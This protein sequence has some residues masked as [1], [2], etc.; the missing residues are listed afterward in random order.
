MILGSELSVLKYD[1]LALGDFSVEFDFTVKAGKIVGDFSVQGGSTPAALLKFLEDGSIITYDGTVKLC[2]YDRRTIHFIINYEVAHHLFEIGVNGKLLVKKYSADQG[3]IK[4]IFDKC[5]TVTFELQPIGGDAEVTVENLKAYEKTGLGYDFARDILLSGK[6]YYPDDYFAKEILKE[7]VAWHKRSGILTVDGIKVIEPGGAEEYFVRNTRSMPLQIIYTDE[8]SNH[9]G[10]IIYGKTEKEAL[11][12]LTKEERQKLNDYCFYFRP[13]AEKILS[14]Y[15]TSECCQRHPRVLSS[16]GEFKQLRETIRTDQYKQEWFTNLIA[17]CDDVLP[18]QET[19]RYEL[20]DGV[21]LLY[22][23]SDFSQWM[24]CL[25]LAYQLTGKRK[26][27]KDAWRHIEAVSSFPDWNPVHHIDVGT[28]GMGFAVAYDWFYECMTPKQRG[29][30]ENAVSRNLFWIVNNAHE[31]KGTSYGNVLMEDNHNPFCNAGI[32]ACCMAFMDVFPEVTSNIASRTIRVL[33]CFLDKFVPD[34]A[35]FEGPDYATVAVGFTVRMFAVIKSCL[36][37]LYGLDKAEGFSL[38]ASYIDNMQSDVGAF[39]FADGDP[40]LVVIPGMLW[41]YDHYGIKGKK[42][43]LIKN[44]LKKETGENAAYCLLWYHPE[45][46]ECQEPPVLDVYYCGDD[47]ISMRN[48]F[49][50]GQVFAAIKA[51]KTE[52]VHSH[53]DPGSF[54]FDAGGKRWAFDLGKDDYNLEYK[55]G[56]YDIFRRRAEAHN[57]LLINPNDG[58]MGYVLGSRAD[59]VRYESDPRNVIV[60]I[61]TTALY[62]DKVRNAARGFWFTDKRCSLVIRDELNLNCDSEL[63]WILYTDANIKVDGQ[64]VIMTD[65]IDTARQLK[66]EFKSTCPGTIRIEAAVPF[67]NSPQIPEQLANEE[68]CR[69]CYYMDAVSGNAFVTA[70]LTPLHLGICESRVSDYDKWIDEWIFS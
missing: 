21:R 56:F 51:G 16:A 69:I 55:Y 13:S 64:S 17:F 18:S 48:S 4:V 42:E 2:E 58:S 11:K 25:G 31:S 6:N 26:Y 41:M 1:A 14:D 33:E 66:I 9:S 70:K 37:T 45:T 40:G 10:L 50:P 60:K 43:T 20:R 12:H 7:C 62:G 5:M 59:V 61:D 39:N 53:L 8:E 36:G 34:G 29:I 15:K 46:E 22:V 28:M 19:L 47:I 24:I 49:L 44:I 3:D 32:M 30:M 63:V 68:Y 54:V 35:Y 57:T 67:P 27:F 23:S 38:S 65:K 52:Y